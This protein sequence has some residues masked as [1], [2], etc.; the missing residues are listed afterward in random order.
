MYY[1]TMCTIPPLHVAY[2]VYVYTYVLHMGCGVLSTYSP[3]GD[4]RHLVCFRPTTQNR[5]SGICY[6]GLSICI[7]GVCIPHQGVVPYIS[8][9]MHTMYIS[10][11]TYYMLSISSI[12]SLPIYLLLPMYALETWCMH[13][14]WGGSQ[15]QRIG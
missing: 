6:L 14:M 3:S 1:I 5:G 9:C 15:L 10:I 7:Q 4:I 12:S 2:M 8:M 11:S 13:T